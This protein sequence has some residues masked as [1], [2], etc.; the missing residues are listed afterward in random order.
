MDRLLELRPRVAS[1]VFL[2]TLAKVVGD[3]QASEIVRTLG[4]IED[5][6]ADDA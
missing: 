4:G 1:E 2:R 3:D 6:G 5:A